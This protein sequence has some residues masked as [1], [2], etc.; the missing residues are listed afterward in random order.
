MSKR[1]DDSQLDLDLTGKI[2]SNGEHR[3]Q[4]PAQVVPFSDAATLQVR[5]DAVRRVATSGIFVL[6]PGLRSDE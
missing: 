1:R 2:D 3:Q 6:P 5:R 4:A